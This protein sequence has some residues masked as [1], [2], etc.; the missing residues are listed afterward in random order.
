MS[1][2][3]Q[4]RSRPE[5]PARAPADPGEDR[6][7]ALAAESVEL[8]VGPC[9]TRTAA[10]ALERMAGGDPT[11]LDAAAEHCRRTDSVDEAA[12][13]IA[14][15]LLERA[16]AELRLARRRPQTGTIRVGGPA[17]PLR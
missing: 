11:L 16:A 3:A 14:A 7:V 4:Q 9:S 13:R 8:V 5:D 17:G 10:R 6:V 12:R 15:Q 1:T 2:Q